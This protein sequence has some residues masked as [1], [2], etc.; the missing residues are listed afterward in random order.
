[1][2]AAGPVHYTMDGMGEGPRHLLNAKDDPA[3]LKRENER[4]KWCMTCKVCY[5]AN[6]EILLLPCKHL[7]CCEQCEPTVDHCPL[8]A[9]GKH[10]FATVRVYT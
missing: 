3:I 9:C 2:H 10:I 8:P 7:A 5:S 4:L 6:V 1:M